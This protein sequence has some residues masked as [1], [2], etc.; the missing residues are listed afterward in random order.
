MKRL[1]I[2][3]LA[4]LMGCMAIHA[5]EISQ[6][7]AFQKAQQF[8]PGKQFKQVD[9][10]R[11]P[12]KAERP[13]YVFNAENNG[14]FVVIAANDLMP[15]VLGYAERGNLDLSKAPDNVKWLF[16]YYAEVANSLKNVPANGDAVKRMAARR[17]TADASGAPFLA[18]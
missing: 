12:G 11:A 10:R 7:Q 4:A 6:A 14:G 18:L 15:E 3:M 1:T 17:R 13:F 16:D 5:E 8:M 2:L 9:A